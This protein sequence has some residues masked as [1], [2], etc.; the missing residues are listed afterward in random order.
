[1]TTASRATFLV[2]VH[3]DGGAV[4]E[5]TRTHELVW[6]GRL[7]EIAVQITDWLAV[8]EPDP[9]GGPSDAS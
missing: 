8:S 4:I 7:S 9:S 1:M 5:N 6:L 3:E 2:E